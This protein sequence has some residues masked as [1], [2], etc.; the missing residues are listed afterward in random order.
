MLVWDGLALRSGIDVLCKSIRFDLGLGRGRRERQGTATIRKAH[1]SP[2]QWW[3]HRITK[4]QQSQV[5]VHLTRGDPPAAVSA[6]GGCNTHNPASCPHPRQPPRPTTPKAGE[7]A[8]LAPSSF[9]QPLPVSTAQSRQPLGRASS[10]QERL[11]RRMHATIA[12]VRAAEG[13]REP[14]R[15]PCVA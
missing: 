6:P 10:S 3:E 7:P 13:G 4:R 9:W 5:V 15:I 2:P 8:R 12:C 1:A 14:R 11:F